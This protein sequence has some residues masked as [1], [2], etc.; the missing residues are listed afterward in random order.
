M[1]IVKGRPKRV[2]PPKIKAI[3]TKKRTARVTTKPVKRVLTPK[4]LTA[5]VALVKGGTDDEAGAVA[6]VGRQSISRWR[7]DPMFV[8]RLN[9]E[10]NRVARAAMNTYQ[11]WMTKA[12]AS[13][14]NEVG[15]AIM[16][17]DL[18]TSRWLL[19][20]VGIENFAKLIFEQ[21]VSPVLAPEDTG[22][23]IDVMAGENVDAFLTEKGVSPL[24]RLRLREALTAKEAEALRREFGA[25]AD[26]PKAPA[27]KGI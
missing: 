3:Y 4:Q 18:A 27:S 14:V 1:C 16:R 10:Q 25:G 21:T 23:V 9:A 6:G 7:H 13:A 8:A 17:G 24:E 5:I 11:K 2:K 12:T 19:E 26:S 20:K 15:K 22:A